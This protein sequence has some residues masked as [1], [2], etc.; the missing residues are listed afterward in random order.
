[1][2]VKSPM[3]KKKPNA[4]LR[5]ANLL[6]ALSGEVQRRGIDRS[7][8]HPNAT[9]SSAAALN[10]IGLMDGC[11]NGALASALRLSHPAT[12]RLIDKL[13]GEGLVTTGRADD[14]RAVAL[15]LTAAGRAEARAI[16]AGRVEAVA[17][18]LDALKP[19]QRRALADI[20][21]TLLRAAATDFGEAM[22]I[23]RLCDDQVCVPER[24]PVHPVVDAY[25]AER[26]AK[27]PA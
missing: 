26:Q 20:A 13:V 7:D 4:D 9:E 17:G 15:R 11:S 16:V 10:L 21:E 19:A 23:C 2:P 1:M 22:H 3:T 5:V 8:R 6:A 24:C 14:R 27:A 25:L 12:A 18:L